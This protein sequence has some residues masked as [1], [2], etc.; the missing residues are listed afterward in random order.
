[1]SRPL[2]AAALALLAF[3]ALADHVRP[4]TDPV[5]V[6]ACGECHMA[7]QPAFLPA[8]SWNK[9]MD[10]LADH[11][12][13]NAT[14]AADKADHIRKVLVDGAADTGG[15]K[16][17]GKV[18]RRLDPATTPLRITETPAFQRKHQLPA[19][20]WARPGVVTRSNCPAC[21]LRA[22]KGDY[23]D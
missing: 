10:N 18:M 16:V 7:F 6:Q 3:P 13:D 2:L 4:V 20:E 17:G 1:M 22:D 21:H 9:M 11:F 8:R 19:S 5:T 14:M 15:G 12:G 23:E